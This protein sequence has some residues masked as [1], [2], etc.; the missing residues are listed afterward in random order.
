MVPTTSFSSPQSRPVVDT[1]VAGLIDKDSRDRRLAA[2]DVKLAA[3]DAAAVAIIEVPRLDWTWPPPEV[4]AVLRTIW[5]YIQL[6]D[7]GQPL[8]AGWLVPEWRAP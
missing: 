6:D 5:N 8:R 3:L 1:F 7:R 4:N 2:L